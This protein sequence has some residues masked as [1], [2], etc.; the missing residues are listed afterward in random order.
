MTI[1]GI[2]HN[3]GDTT[4][5]AFW[6]AL[7]RGLGVSVSVLIP[8]AGATSIPARPRKGSVAFGTIRALRA[9]RVHQL[10]CP[11]LA[12]AVRHTGASV[13]H[14]NAEPENF[15]AW[16]GTRLKALVPGLRLS[17]VS[18]RNIRYPGRRLPYRFGRVYTAIERRTLKSADRIFCFNDDAMR[19]LKSYGARRLSRVCAG[20]DTAIFRPGNKRTGKG[21]D[22]GYAGRLVPEKGVD[23]LVRAMAGGGNAR[24]NILGSGPERGKLWKLAREVGIAGRTRFIPARPQSALPAFYRSVD[25]LVLPSVSTPG[26]KEQFGRVLIEA[27]ACGTPVIGSD[28]GEIPRVIGRAGMIFREGDVAGIRRAIVRLRDD[29][30]LRHRLARAGRRRVL[31]NFTVA[32]MVHS[33]AA[34]FRSLI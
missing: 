13:L 27:M 16:Q 4:G 31:A 25:A 11:G 6:A 18:W 26:W 2:D 20:V 19:I 3:A 24:L 9:S 17:L 5:R 12:G 8:G 15:L 22:A 29:P 1:L 30:G 33:F 34:G 28:S 21:F 32:H 7:A 10:V 23:L 14:L